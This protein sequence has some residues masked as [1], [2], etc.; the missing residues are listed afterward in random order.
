MD[1]LQVRDKRVCHM[2]IEQRRAAQNVEGYT[3][4]YLQDIE[5]FLFRQDLVDIGFEL[6]ERLEEFCSEGALC[7]GFDLGFRTWRESVGGGSEFVD[8]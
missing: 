7:R 3:V 1:E 2:L 8:L 4:R 6:R 5:L